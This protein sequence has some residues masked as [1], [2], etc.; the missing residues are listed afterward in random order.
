MPRVPGRAVL[1]G[2]R[3]DG[4]EWAVQRRVLVLGG[5]GACERVLVRLSRGSLQRRV[6]G[7]LS[8]GH[9]LSS[10][11]RTAHALPAGRL[12]NFLVVVSLY[13]DMHALLLQN[14]PVGTYHSCASFKCMDHMHTLPFRGWPTCSMI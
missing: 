4:A 6:R 10:R 14:V 5:I 1:R 9:L 7:H 13:K 12:S 11:L 3:A 2:A 8:A